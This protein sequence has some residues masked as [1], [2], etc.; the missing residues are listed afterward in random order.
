MTDLK[1]CPFCGSRNIRLT[2]VIETVV[3]VIKDERLSRKVKF[4]SICEECKAKSK[5]FT[6]SHKAVDDWNRRA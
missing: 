4:Y 6:S 1:P 5:E 2:R 3:D